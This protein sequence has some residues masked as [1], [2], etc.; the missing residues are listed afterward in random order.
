MVVHMFSGCGALVGS[1]L[2]GP[3]VERLGDNFRDVALPGHSLP[4]TAVGA[5]LVIIGMVGKI[6][7]SVSYG[8]FCNINDLAI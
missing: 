6:A 7:G 5:M 2:V 8:L 3:R 1:L 4:L